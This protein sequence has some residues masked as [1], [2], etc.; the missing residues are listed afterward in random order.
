MKKKIDGINDFFKPFLHIEN[1]DLK[2][3]YFDLHLHT[4][5][6][7]SLIS[8]EELALFLNKKN[9]LI[10]ITDHNSIGGVLALEKCGI[11]VVPGIELGCEDGMELLV[12]FKNSSTCEDF[13]YNHILPFKHPTR[14]ARTLKNIWYY[15]D[16]LKKYD[17]YIS[18]PHING[19][20]QKNFLKNKD[21]IFKLLE[22]VNAIEVNNFALSTKKNSVAK[23]LKLI[24]DLEGTYGSDAHSMR[25]VI[26][27]YRYL[28]KKHSVFHNSVDY[29]YKLNSVTQIGIK[30]FKYMI[31]NT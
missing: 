15:I 5:D 12:Y 14:M 30:H 28:N 17:A 26:S 24:Y 22:V 2:S 16:I 18:I 6:S 10:A 3:F 13:Y 31:S 27:F 23:N 7:D 19:I 9:Y 21:Y 1:L 25:E 11:K 29:A 8:P 20:A 4:V